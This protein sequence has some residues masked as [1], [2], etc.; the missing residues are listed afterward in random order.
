[1]I[2][3]TEIGGDKVLVALNEFPLLARKSMRDSWHEIGKELVRESISLINKKPKTGRI[4]NKYYGISAGKQLKRLKTVKKHIA[5][6]AG[7]APAV[8]TGNL[9]KSINHTVLGKDGLDFGV[10]YQR[11]YVK[12]AKYLE[13]ENPV[14][15]TGQVSEKIK[16][17]PFISQAYKN[18]QRDI[19]RIFMDNFNK[20][21]L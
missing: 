20:S 1:M 17:R 18:K 13:Y 3:I 8:I 16:P 11:A 21:K 7:E 5:S 9:R 10:D 2:K 14:T 19:E 4:Y 6:A 15:Q 12:Y